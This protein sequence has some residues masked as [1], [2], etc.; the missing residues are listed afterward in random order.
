MSAASLMT[1]LGMACATYLTRILGYL[2]LRNRTLNPRTRNVLERAPGCVMLSVIAPYF[3]A[4]RPEELIAIIVTVACAWR[5][6]ML[7]TM[8]I[9]VASLGLLKALLG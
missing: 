5:L 1:I 7:P 8:V 4:S 9:S 2:A 3:V 6:P